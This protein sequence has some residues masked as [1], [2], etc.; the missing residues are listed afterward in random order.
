MGRCFVI[1]ALNSM[2]N[3]SVSVS[4]IVHLTLYSGKSS[5]IFEWARYV[6]TLL[7]VLQIISA[8]SSLISIIFCLH[9]TPFSCVK[10]PLVVLGIFY[11]YRTSLLIDLLHITFMYAT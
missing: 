5:C 10:H 2:K 7:P 4:Q 8:S 3:L 11:L 9:R 1:I 6:M